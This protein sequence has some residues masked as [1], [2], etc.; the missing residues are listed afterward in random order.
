MTASTLSLAAVSENEALDIGIEAYTYAYPLVLMELTRRV[1]TNVAR[2]DALRLRGPMNGFTHA[3]AFPDASFKDVVRPNADTLYSSLWFDVGSEPLVVTMPHSPDRYHVL[4]IMDLW[5]DVFATVGTRTTGGVGGAFALV[6]P[7]CRGTLPD[8]LR[9]ITSPTD[10]G[11]IIGRIQTN[12]PADFDAVRSIQQQIDAVP[13][14]AWGTPRTPASGGADPAIGMKT[15]PVDQ[16][17]TLSA[18]AFFALAAELMKRNP[19]HAADVPMVLRLERLGILAGSSFSLDNASPAVQRALK[20][21]GPPALARIVTWGPRRRVP[22]NGWMRP[23][24]VH[25]VY[26]TDYL[27]R[28][29]TAYVGLGA[30]LSDEAIYLSA[31]DD[32]ESRHLSGAHRYVLHFERDRTPPA[33]AFWSLTMYGA[34]QCFVDNPVDRYAIGDR[35]ALAFNADGS[36]DLHIQHETP[37]ADKAA[38][39][40]PAPAGPFSMNLRLY[41]PKAE[42]LDGRWIPPTVQRIDDTKAEAARNRV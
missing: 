37:A 40:L 7:H 13:L 21:A 38:N 41:W 31:F 35:D 2:P 10:A 17:A 1:M 15:P 19:P 27:N 42:A 33:K 36:L 5:T 9:R 25:G 11:W 29:Y 39:W 3:A 23:S 4:P 6:G 26:G 34:D 14:S 24:G 22:H 12:G 32:G 16:V 28:A 20:R 30:L 8:G 18:D